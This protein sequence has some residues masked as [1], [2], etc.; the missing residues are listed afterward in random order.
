MTIRFPYSRQEVTEADAAAV[1]EALFSDRLTQGPLVSAFET[2]LASTVGAQSAVACNSGTA[3]LHL[4]YAAVGL[5]PERGL[6]TT[7]VTFLATA[8]AARMLGAPVVFAD[9]DPHTGNLDPDAVRETLRRTQVPIGC[10]APVHLAGQPCDM[11]GLQAVA[12]AFGL[13][14]VEDACHALGATYR[15][16]AG[17]QYRVGACAHSTAAAFSFHAIKHA[18]MGEGGAV[19]TNDAPV[20][21]RMRRLR[22]HGMVHDPE[23]F[24]FEP[25]F[26]APWYYEMAELGFNY[27]LT[28]IQCALGRSQL[29]RLSDGLAERRRIAAL[30][31]GLLA[32][33]R[34]VRLP[35]P[36][37]D[38]EGHAWHLFPL[39]IDFAAIGKTRG[40][41]MRELAARGIG[42][43]V[44]Y[45][46][47]CTQPYYR[48]LGGVPLP[49]AT[50]YYDRTLS[51][52]MY[53]ALSDEDVDTIAAHIRAVLAC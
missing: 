21:Q 31:Y 24:Q 14:I 30:Y 25:E 23:E 35:T 41:V 49:N 29:A 1:R 13:A 3:A 44:H 11:P 32:E 18:A 4:A 33:L 36:V 5:G 22:S 19:C 51:I 40:Q 43:Q 45:I 47:V 7:P 37:Q 9:V 53:P 42:T 10:I 6:L 8:N 50:Y 26:S 2:D 27:R 12:D 17:Q 46:P 20:A 52:P 28:D 48:V 15:D 39:A 16:A 34:H 38:P